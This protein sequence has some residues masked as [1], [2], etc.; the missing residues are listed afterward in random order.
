M[1]FAEQ[2]DVID[3]LD[4]QLSPVRFLLFS[5]EFTLVNFPSLLGP[6]LPS[7]PLCVTDTDVDRHT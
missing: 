4:A 6:C 3:N 2:C 5:P 1:M 7:C